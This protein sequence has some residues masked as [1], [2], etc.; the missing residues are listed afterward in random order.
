MYFSDVCEEVHGWV[1]IWSLESQSNDWRVASSNPRMIWEICIG[2]VNM[3][4]PPS[5]HNNNQL[6]LEHGT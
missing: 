4:C 2:A 5:L 6:A 1:A 3:C